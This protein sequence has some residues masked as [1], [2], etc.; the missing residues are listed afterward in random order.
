MKNSSHIAST[1]QF[2]RSS[3]F[4]FFGFGLLAVIFRFVQFLILGDPPLEEL[5]IHKAFPFLQGYPSLLAAIFFLLG[6]VALH[7][8]QA[9]QTGRAGQIIFFIAFSALVISS[10]AM[11]T[12]AFTAPVLAREAPILLT[13]PTS[14]IVQA[15][16]AAMLVGQVGWLL[17]AA[18]SVWANVIPRWSALIAVVSILIAIGLVP[19]AKTQFLRLV[20][21]TLLGAGPL[22]VGYVL[23]RGEGG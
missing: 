22:A 1:D 15:V 20:F 2:I 10:G 21:N 18:T 13:S 4:L 23:W 9:H 16:L 12:Y 11:W 3:G 19:F 14:G 8:R 17:M 6:T 7:L 5:V